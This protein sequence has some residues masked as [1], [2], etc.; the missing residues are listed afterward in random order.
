M[1]IL[2]L[3]FTNP[4]GYPPLLHSSRILAERGCD[5]LF[6]GTGAY[7]TESLQIPPHPRIRERRVGPYATG[8]RQKTLYGRFCLRA[9]LCSSR[10]KPHWIY[11]SD[12][13]SCPA[14]LLLARLFSIPVV[15]HEHDSPM[16]HGCRGVVLRARHMLA[17]RARLCVLPNQARVEQFRVATGRT[18]ACNAVWN[19]PSRTEALRAALGHGEFI[20]HYHGNL[21]PDLVP[22]T[23]LDALAKTP[24][25][26]LDV[27]GYATKGQEHYPAALLA[28]AKR[29]CLL[30]RVRVRPAMPRAEMLEETRRA[31]LGIALTPAQSANPNFE[32]MVGASNKPFEYLAC[33]VPALVSDRPDWRTA[34]QA[35]GYGLSCDPRDA[36]SIARVLRWATEHRDAAQSM[37]ERGR[38]KI[39]SDWNYERQ[40]EPVARQ[41]I[42]PGRGSPDDGLGS[43]GASRGD[44]LGV[45]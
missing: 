32:T 18:G 3:Q 4:A 22:M 20:L 7:G 25:T 16:S 21:G 31:S 12:P 28:E 43:R 35:P 27:V 13:L 26:R 44:E 15:Y 29:R 40:F 8:W 37:G 6:L 38:Q 23:L 10:W 24:G 30:N 17:R 2:F 36:D 33:G 45:A 5:I 39:L 42:C 9:L 41:L 19:C 11:A 1:R 14:A 34:F